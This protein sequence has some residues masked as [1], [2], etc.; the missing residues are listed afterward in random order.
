MMTILFWVLLYINVSGTVAP[1]PHGPVPEKTVEDIGRVVVPMVC[2]SLSPDQG[3]TIMATGFFVKRS[4][5]II[6]AG[7]VI[8]LGPSDFKKKGF[9][10][11][12]AIVVPLH[13]WPIRLI[14]GYNVLIRV[15]SCVLPAEDDVTACDLTLN[16]FD[17]PELVSHIGVAHTDT[18]K[19]RVGT[20]VSLT[21][22]KEGSQTPLTFDAHVLE[23]TPTRIGPDIVLDS[24]G[25]EGMSGA[26][27]YL[28]NGNV[29]GVMTHNSG[30]MSNARPASV[31]QHLL[32][33]KKTDLGGQ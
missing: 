15:R 12:P 8:T 26:P 16:P 2:E 7:H 25:G 32:T 10:C 1:P 3:F 5:T 4:G 9:P 20:P 31:I 6:T 13:G 23:L 33:K 14:A 17:S 29:I 11:V 18:S 22:F 21:G 30:T 24:P 19:L 28:D 27:V